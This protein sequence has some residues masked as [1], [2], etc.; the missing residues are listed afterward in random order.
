[1]KTVEVIEPRA[2]A[3]LLSLSDERI[4]QVRRSGELTEFDVYIGARAITV[5]SWESAR[6]TFL[7]GKGKELSPFQEQYLKQIRAGSIVIP[8]SYSDEEGEGEKTELKVLNSGAFRARR[9]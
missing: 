2:L 9:S 4:R 6:N 8:L 7:K 1:M 3:R 5:I